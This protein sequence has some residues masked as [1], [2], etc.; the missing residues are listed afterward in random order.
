MYFAIRVNGD[1]EVN[2]EQLD[3]THLLERLNEDY[4]GSPKILS[5]IPDD[6]PNYWGGADNGAMLIL[7][8]EIV[9]PTPKQVVQEYE[10]E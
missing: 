5:D 3:K 10:I 4:Y 2:V 9:T 6:D 1:G 8:G 7:K